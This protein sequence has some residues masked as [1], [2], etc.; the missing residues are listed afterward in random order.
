MLDD[1]AEDYADGDGE[2]AVWLRE[3][4][5]IVDASLDLGI[6]DLEDLDYRTSYDAG[7]TP[8]DCVK[9]VVVPGLRHS[10]S[11]EVADLLLKDLS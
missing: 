3:V 11:S 10:W 1:R 9:E 5:K 8:V 6:F 7:D 2:F 4:D